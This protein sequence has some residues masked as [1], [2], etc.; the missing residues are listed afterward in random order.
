MITCAYCGQDT[1]YEGLTL[2][3]CRELAA[4]RL[5]AEERWAWRDEQ[6]RV[7]LSLAMLVQQPRATTEVLSRTELRRIGEQLKAFGEA[8]V[9]CVD[10]EELELKMR[11]DP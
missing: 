11:G 8:I 2:H 9:A 7:L 5:R 1:T 4:A 10:G 6:L 3:T